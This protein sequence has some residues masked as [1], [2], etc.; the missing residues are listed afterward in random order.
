MIYSNVITTTQLSNSGR[1]PC[2][3]SENNFN[4]SGE[5]RT[6][7]PVSNFYVKVTSVLPPVFTLI[8]IFTLLF[9]QPPSH[10]LM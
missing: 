4:A 9:V 10:Q 7:P 8:D 1:H 2:F 3:R 5:S 6:H